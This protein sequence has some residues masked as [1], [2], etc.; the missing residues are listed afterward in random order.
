VSA[1]YRV[2]PVFIIRLSGVPFEALERLATSDTVV[3]AQQLS[4]HEKECAKATAEVER[5]FQ[6]REQ[7]LPYEAYRA[8]C[9]AVRSGRPLDPVSENAPAFFRRYAAAAT[10]LAAAE[11]AL[12]NSLKNEVCAARSALHE[13]ASRFLPAYLV[14]ASAEITNLLTID[15]HNQLPP[16]NSRERKRER[17]L[18]LYLQRIAAKNDT[19]SEFGPTG[20]G[21]V[22]RRISGIMLAPQPG[23]SSREVFWERWTAHAVADVINADPEVFEELAPRLNPCG[24]VHD[25]AFILMDA[26]ETIMVSPQELDL[27]KRCDGSTPVHAI[28]VPPEAIRSLVEKKI[29]QCALEVPALEAHA[30]ETLHNDVEKWRLGK[31]R[32]RWLSLLQTLVE[33]APVFANSTVANERREILSNASLRLEAVGAV[34]KEG[35]RFLYSAANPIGE[36]CFRETK[37]SIAEQLVNEVAEDAAPWIDFWRDSYAFVAARVAAGLR[38]IFAQLNENNRGIPLPAFLRSCAAAGL[39]LTGPGL[40]GLAVVAFE[41]VKAAF[42]ERLSAHLD[43]DEYEL[44]VEDCHVVRN[45]FD[46][47]KFDAYTYPS[48]DLQLSAASVTAVERG[49]YQW[50]VGELHP[51]GAM[52]HHCFYWCCPDKSAFHEALVA[53]VSAEPNFH[54]GFVPVDFTSHTT[55]RLFDALSQHSRFVAPERCKPE[56]RSVR[57]ADAEV[58]VDR[59]SGDVCLRKADSHQYLGSFARAWLIPLGFHPFQF[60]IVPHTPRLRCGR[61]I[62]QR[63]TWTLKR[64]EL[65]VSNVTG[66]SRQLA[67]A[68]E[69]LRAQKGW[70][71]HIF[72]RPTEQVLRRSGAEG[73]DK[74]TKPVFIDLESYLFI[75]IF[76]RW[77]VKA[78][79]IEVTEMLPDPDHLLWREA[80]GRRTFELRTLIVPRE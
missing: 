50:I 47:P 68:V 58:Y 64:E 38:G 29:L 15:E 20:W 73:R 3:R 25:D 60:G 36:E 27:I 7:L 17:R 53:A 10:G 21:K 9:K 41:E 72:I 32:E 77:L 13:S 79:E 54:F 63:R 24:R 78:G 51:A 23:I 80:D 19:F 34:R 12:D 8:L 33:M 39:S 26:D 62:V 59:T 74:D 1:G 56:W 42:R 45:N 31:V 5:F 66:L 48:A 28:G 30:L 40:I 18:L 55:V 65:P 43:T 16:R 2:A 57:P 70:P 14:F 4:D 11:S 22:D 46:Y 37:F 69:L 35:Q 75:E 61:V 49:E 76:Y 6:S 44:S 52:L 67:V 71:R